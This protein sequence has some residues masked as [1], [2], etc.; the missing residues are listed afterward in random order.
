[1]NYDI[2]VVTP[3][4][5]TEEYLHRCIQSVLSQ[6]NINIQYFLIDDSSNDNS[7]SIAQYYANLDS[8][9]TFLRNSQNLGQ[10][11]SR[12]KAIKLANAEYIYFVDS[13]DY[14]ETPDTL[15]NLFDT[16]KKYQLDICSPDVP[17]HYFDKPLEAIACIPCKSQFIR[18]D[19]I[20]DFEILQPNI[21]SGQDGVFSHLILTHCTRIGMTKEAK[22]HYTHARE[23]STFSSYLKNH[24]AVSNLIQRHYEAIISHYD[25]HHLWE[26]NALR[27][28]C[29][30]T[31]ETIRNRIFP[32]YDYLTNQQK[33]EC[34][35][36][37]KKI[38]SKI[39]S[40]IQKNYHNVIHPMILDL[41]DQSL[42]EFVLSF[43]R[44]WKNYKH[45]YNF[46]ANENIIKK[47]MII[48]KI[49]DNKLLPEKKIKQNITT[50]PN[51]KQTTS[52]VVSNDKVDNNIAT[53]DL[54]KLNQNINSL[55]NELKSIKG[56]LDLTLNT[57]NNST[58]RLL[59]AIRSERTSLSQVYQKD[60]VISLTTLPHRLP[61]VHYTIESIFSQTILPEKVI[62]WVSDAINDNLITPELKSLVNRG[63]EIKKAKDVGPHTKLIY[64]L[65]EYP[66]KTI[67]TVDD[68]IIYPANMLQYLWEQH[69]NFPQ[70]IV[71]NWARELSFDSS[72]KVRGVRSGKLLTPILLENEIEQATAFNPKPNILAFPYGTSGVLY[73]PNSLHEQVT[74]VEL[75]KKL[76]PKEDD[77][78][79]KAMG[80]LNKTPVVVTNLGINPVHHSLVG[81]QQIALRHDNHGLNQNEKQMRAVFDYFDLYKLVR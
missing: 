2:A 72:G 4:Y 38:S 37:I 5:N 28:A 74:N 35:K 73:P 42:E 54:A 8:R 39:I 69:I 64:S 14:L 16:A 25:K 77:I 57:L 36:P 53:I 19:I 12:N 61:L 51:N 60:L 45:I 79:F 32:H 7:S 63:L 48:C 15:K 18:L 1:M 76:C 20:K 66:N 70:A 80:I 52:T 58:M 62:L 43:E 26:K 23:G 31:D 50:I 47:E 41:H 67:V 10:G 13:D 55:Q 78:W 71:A 9:I 33:L 40:N 17:S 21:R 46:K 49:A 59:S 30:L 3:F 27:L 68:D 56:K 81:T 6:K 34:F 29:F 44:K 22:F 65:I 11:E 24:D 75:F